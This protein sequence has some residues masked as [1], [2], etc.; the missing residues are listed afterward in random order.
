MEKSKVQAV[1][2]DIERGEQQSAA[3]ETVPQES[4]LQRLGSKLEA[5]LIAPRCLDSSSIVGTDRA[6][7]RDE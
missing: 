7:S 2:D 3:G 5:D 6:K 1:L 4:V